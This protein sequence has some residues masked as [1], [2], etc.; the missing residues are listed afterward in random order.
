[1]GF[2]CGNLGFD[3]YSFCEIGTRGMCIGKKGVEMKKTLL[4]AL[5]ALFVCGVAFAGYTYTETETI[6]TYERFGAEIKCGQGC[7]K[8]FVSSRDVKPCAKKAQPLRVKTH[9]EI[10]DHYQVYQPV[11]V[12][13]PMGTEIQ[14]R[15]VK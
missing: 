14:R 4:V 13:K 11:V 5:G 8:R 3:W 12:Y 7:A 15:I 10:I 9:T 2:F 1:M 6:T